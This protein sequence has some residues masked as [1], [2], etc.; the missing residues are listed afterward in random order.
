MT[1]EDCMKEMLISLLIG[2]IVTLIIFAALHAVF[3]PVEVV[4]FWV[5]TW[6]ISTYAVWTIIDIL[7]RKKA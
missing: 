2:N 4:G 5:G 3:T 1:R 7:D 6:F